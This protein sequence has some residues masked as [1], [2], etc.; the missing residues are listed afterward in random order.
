VSALR[1]R[2]QR[3]RPALCRHRIV[4]RKVAKAVT[5]AACVDAIEDAFKNAGR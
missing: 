2:S 4:F 3:A 1:A 5:M